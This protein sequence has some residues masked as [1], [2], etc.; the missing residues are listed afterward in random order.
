[1]AL[2]LHIETATRACSVALSE[3]GQ[4]IA[5]KELA[6]ESFVHGE[7]LTLFIQAV[8]NDSGKELNELDAVSVSAGP[9]SYTGLRI[10]AATAKGLCYA[11]GVPLMAIDSLHALAA[12][13]REDYPE[14][15]LCPMIDARRMEVYTCLLDSNHSE[16]LPVDA[17]IIEEQTF[18]TLDP[19]LYFGDG[20]EKLTALWQNRS[21]KF[22]PDVQASAKGQCNIANQHFLQKKICRLSLLGTSLPKRFCNRKIS[23]DRYLPN[24]VG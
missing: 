20:A 4:L 5:I 16:L 14:H 12:V 17:V 10:G 11:L 6:D 23:D 13:V 19:F 8:M 22:L 7:Q 9:G 3:K 1:M 21:S 15:R 24:F 2:I 18:S